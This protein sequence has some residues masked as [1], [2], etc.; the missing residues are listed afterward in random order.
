LLPSTY[1]C[2]VTTTTISDEQLKYAKQQ[3][4]AAGLSGQITLLD[5]DYRLL[6]GQYDKIVSVEMIEA[7]GKKYLPGFFKKLNDL[8]KPNGLMMLQAITIADQRYQGI[9]S[10]RGLY[11][12][13]HFP[14][15]IPAI[16]ETDDRNNGGQD[17]NDS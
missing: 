1:G 16:N 12:E 7:V 4:E 6:Q 3:V 11:P 15:R 14:W 5:Q 13:A 17:G 2:R 10:Q 8:L 9:Q